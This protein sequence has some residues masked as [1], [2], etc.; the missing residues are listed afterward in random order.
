MTG[1]II[2][3]LVGPTVRR[4]TTAIK[5]FWQYSKDQQ[6]NL[7]LSYNEVKCRPL[8]QIKLLSNKADIGIPSVFYHVSQVYVRK[9]SPGKETKLL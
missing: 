9:N 1:R 7:S 3:S 4:L 5:P 2:K 6:A 8:N